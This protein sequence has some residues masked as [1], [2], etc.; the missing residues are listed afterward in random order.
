[1]LAKVN[2]SSIKTKIQL[3]FTLA[4]TTDNLVTIDMTHVAMSDNII[5]DFNH[6][7]R[8]TWSPHHVT[9]YYFLVLDHTC[10]LVTTS[11]STILFFIQIIH[12]TLDKTR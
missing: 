2:N 10:H 7:K 4:S 1:M 8:A 6:I 9:L 3:S 11:C 5:L 12:A